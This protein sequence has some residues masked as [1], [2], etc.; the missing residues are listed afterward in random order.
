MQKNGLWLVKLKVRLPFS[1]QRRKKNHCHDI[2]RF[3]K[4]QNVRSPA[5]AHSF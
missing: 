1:V 5:S 2:I 4:D 3:N